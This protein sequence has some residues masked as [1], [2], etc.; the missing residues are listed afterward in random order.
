M[1]AA[2][3]GVA[4]RHT[5]V[6]ELAPRR[7]D[8]LKVVSAL[9]H[10]RARADE[11]DSE[12][13]PELDGEH[14]DLAHMAAAKIRARAAAIRARMRVDPPELAGVTADAPRLDGEKVARRGKINHCEGPVRQLICPRGA[15][16]YSPLAIE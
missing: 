4:A 9:G 8:K 3:R 1:W 16:A 5:Q 2:P 11:I 12:P 13:P 15:P 6:D 7:L 10:L 14:P